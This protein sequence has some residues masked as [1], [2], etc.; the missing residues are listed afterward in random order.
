MNMN[1]PIRK[2]N[3]GLERLVKAGVELNN[4]RIVQMRR[5][6]EDFAPD[7]EIKYA[8]T[9]ELRRRFG[10][11]YRHHVL[12]Q[13]GRTLV[14]FEVRNKHH[15]GVAWCDDSDDFNPKVGLRIA[16][17]RALKNGSIK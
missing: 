3:R 14:E 17:A 1:L 10:K 15:T 7:A 12:Q 4:V 6:L 5:Y 9:S 2:Q 8:P 13:G 11:D 16:V